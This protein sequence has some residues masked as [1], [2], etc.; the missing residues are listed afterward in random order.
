MHL[1]YYTECNIALNSK[2]TLHKC[3]AIRYMLHVYTTVNY[4]KLSTIP[5]NHFLCVCVGMQSQC[6]LEIQPG[7]QAVSI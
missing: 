3:M 6:L 4:Y 7:N 1:E 5:E 2:L